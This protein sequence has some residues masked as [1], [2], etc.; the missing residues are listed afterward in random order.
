M[1]GPSRSNQYI[2]T[3]VDHFSKW[4]EAIPLRNHTAL[5]V[6]RALMTHVFSKYGAPRQIL[7][8]RGSEFESSLFQELLRWMGIDKLRSTALRPACN[9]V[10][11]RFHRTLNSMLGKVVS[12]S[13]RDWDEWVPFVLSAY[14]ATPMSQLECRRISYFWAMKSECLL[15]F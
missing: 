15:T 8:D 5:T 4:A 2:L 1:T 13:Q 6:A 9:G 10:V 3:L 12:E 11:E 14:R 7:T